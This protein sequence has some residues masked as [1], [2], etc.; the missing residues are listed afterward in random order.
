MRLREDHVDRNRAVAIR[1]THRRIVEHVHR[2]RTVEGPHFDKHILHFA[3]HRPPPFH[4][5]GPRR[6]RRECRARKVS[7]SNPR[8]RRDAQRPSSSARARTGAHADGRHSTAILRKTPPERIS[9]PGRPPSRMSRLEPRP[10]TVSGRSGG[11]FAKKQ[12]QIRFSRRARN[13]SCAGPPVRNQD[14]G[15]CRRIRRERAAQIR[16]RGADV[17]PAIGKA[18]EPALSRRVLPLCAA[19]LAGRGKPFA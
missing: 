10:I 6:W 9:T 17:L 7:P 2:A 3:R 8:F 1:K 12:R 16:D 13:R 19:E 18:A 4:A 14:K 5:Q 11:R 15:A